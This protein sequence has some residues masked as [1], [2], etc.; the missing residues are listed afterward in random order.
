MFCQ[1]G[2]K[3]K[4]MRTQSPD[5]SPEMERGQ[6]D[7]LRKTSISKRFAMIEAWSQFITEAAKQGIR[8]DNANASEHE[9][10]LILVTGR[11]ERRLAERVRSGWAHR[12]RRIQVGLSIRLH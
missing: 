7:V 12:R 8:R 5:T 4:L 6:I 9:V 3:A 1:R 11:Y 2:R 10:A